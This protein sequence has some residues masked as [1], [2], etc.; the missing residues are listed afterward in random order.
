MTELCIKNK[1]LKSKI[2]WN[3]TENLCWKKLYIDF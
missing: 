1:T 3:A 2:N